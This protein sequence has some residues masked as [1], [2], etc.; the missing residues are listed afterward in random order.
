MF[1][2]FKQVEAKKFYEES[3]KI[4]PDYIPAL[5][6]LTLLCHRLGYADEALR[7][8]TSALKM[9][10][11]NIIAKTNYALACLTTSFFFCYEENKIK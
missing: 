2:K 4:K 6:N 10:E 3:L 9:Q 5:N 8:S 11:G 1:Q 7:L